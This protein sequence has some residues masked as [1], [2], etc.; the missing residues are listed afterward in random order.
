MRRL[1]VVGHDAFQRRSSRGISREVV[2]I[3]APGLNLDCKNGAALTNHSIWVVS[4]AQQA[5]LR[6]PGA[7]GREV[8]LELGELS[9]G[10]SRPDSG[11]EM[12]GVDGG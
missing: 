2:G 4:Q 11:E 6:R 10:E 8:T 9:A 5:F 7:S 3:A 12:E 1:A